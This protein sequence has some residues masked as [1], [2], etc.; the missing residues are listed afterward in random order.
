M[1]DLN[2]PSYFVRFHLYFDAVLTSEVIEIPDNKFYVT[3]NL[4]ITKT[5][6]C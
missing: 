2:V 1:S 6:Y 4:Y 5:L 3:K